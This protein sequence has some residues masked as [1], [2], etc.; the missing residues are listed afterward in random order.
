MRYTG[1]PLSQLALPFLFCSLPLAM[2]VTA[3]F[4][5]KLRIDISNRRVAAFRWGIVSSIL[6]TLVTMTCWSD[7]Y[8]LRRFPDG[9]VSTGWIDL[10]WAV[11]LGAILLIIV[12]A[13]FGKGRARVLLVLS[14][15]LSLA[16][17]FGSVLQNGV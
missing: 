12:L 9:S 13:S 8:P 4:D 14:G 7:L 3:L 1:L 16:L 11:A 17:L 5:K 6:G 15:V 10:A 2:T